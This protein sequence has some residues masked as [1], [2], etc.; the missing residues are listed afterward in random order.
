MCLCASLQVSSEVI[1][2]VIDR[3][4]VVTTYSRN[5]D[6]VGKAILTKSIGSTAPEIITLTY[7]YPAG[8][9]HSYS[10][11]YL[12]PPLRTFE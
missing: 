2:S 3:Y 7:K 9:V 1:S 12:I 6:Y 8:I 5:K 4:K 10:L 11:H